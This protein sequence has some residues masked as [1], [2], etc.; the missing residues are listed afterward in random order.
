MFSSRSRKSQPR[1]K[2][3]RSARPWSRRRPWLYLEPLEERILLDSGLPPALVVG[4]TLSSYT[5]AGIQDNQLS[6]TY[7][8]YNEQGHPLSGVRLTDT[9]Q[10][11]VTF[12]SASQPADLGGQKLTWRLGTIPGYGRAS[13][14]VTVSLANPVPLQLDA[15]AQA[16]ATLDAGTVSDSSPA[17]TLRPGS[18]DASL[19]AST[20]DASSTDPII[21]EEAARLAYDPQQIL[22]FLHTAVGYES[23]AG[24]VR[25]ARGTLWSS[26]GNAL[27]VASLGVA[28]M[29]ASGIPACGWRCGRPTACRCPGGRGRRPSWSGHRSPPRC[30]RARRCSR[31]APPPWPLPSRS[32]TS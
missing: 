10:P 1:T 15:G 22:N 14:T 4:R 31:Q 8:V 2:P 29:R 9:L 28:L 16:V 11:G 19:L 26:A 13:V 12:Q 17:A 23:Y 32:P 30:R 6:L 21:Q 18:V 3:S 24:S 7:T 27:D 20:P 5:T 25:G